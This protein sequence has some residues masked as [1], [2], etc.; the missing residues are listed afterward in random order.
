MSNT[1]YYASDKICSY[2]EDGKNCF[3]IIDM[4]SNKICIVKID[5]KNMGVEFR[6]DEND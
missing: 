4:D 5:F 6:F 3:D 1:C 2:T